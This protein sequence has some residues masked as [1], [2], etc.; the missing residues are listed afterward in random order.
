MEERDSK[1]LTLSQGVTLMQEKEMRF[2]YKGIDA[3]IYDSQ[4]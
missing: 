3:D 4:K 2:K 1:K